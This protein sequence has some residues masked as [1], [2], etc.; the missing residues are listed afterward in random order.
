MRFL[1]DENQHA[2]LEPFLKAL[3]HDAIFIQKGTADDDIVRIARAEKRIC[4]T[5]DKDFADVN[6]FPMHGHY[7]I[8]LLRINPLFL[9]QIKDRLKTLF[10]EWSESRLCSTTVAVFEDEF[11]DLG[12]MGAAM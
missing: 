10:G 5:Y 12:E 3:G 11:V 8:I 7:G 9:S 1:L 4:I 2:K 6:K